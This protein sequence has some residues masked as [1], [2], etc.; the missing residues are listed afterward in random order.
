M[1]SILV[2]LYSYGTQHRKRESHS[3][4]RLPHAPTLMLV[5][6]RK[7]TDRIAF[8]TTPL[9][10]TCKVLRTKRVIL[11]SNHPSHR[12]EIAEHDAIKTYLR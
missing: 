4:Q 5:L 10:P 6:R 8:Q 3:F 9:P 11:P 1:L 2:Y 7:S 12:A